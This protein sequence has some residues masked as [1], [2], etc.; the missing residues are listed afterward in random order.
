MKHNQNP[1]LSMQCTKAAGAYVL[2]LNVREALSLK[3]GRFGRLEFVPGR[4]LYLGSAYGL[5]GI[6]ARVNR[7]VQTKGR[8]QH[9]H[10]D[11]LSAVT[12]VD[13][14]WAIPG[15]KEC[16]LVAAV[17]TVPETSTPFPGFG[18]SDC[19][20]CLAHLVLAGEDLSPEDLFPVIQS[21]DT[22]AD[23]DL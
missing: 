17:L 18:S 10:I 14:F 7:H 1:A 23:V 9:W 3:V 20:V 19:K 13:R 11:C 12:G 8:R 4:Y 22:S 21:R 2:E 5:G 6:A 15:G 16:E